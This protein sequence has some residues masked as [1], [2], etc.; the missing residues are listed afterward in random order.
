MWVVVQAL[1]KP[2]LL[3]CCDKNTDPCLHRPLF[4]K[5]FDLHS[6]AVTCNYLTHSCNTRV[7]QRAVYDTFPLCLVMCPVHMMEM[8]CVHIEL[9][10][11]VTCCLDTATSSR[12]QSFES[13]KEERKKNETHALKKVHHSTQ[14]LTQRAFLL[15]VCLSVKRQRGTRW[16]CAHPEEFSGW[17]TKQKTATPMRT[18][19][20]ARKEKNMEK[21]LSIPNTEVSTNSV[22]GKRKSLVF[23][24]FSLLLSLFV[25]ISG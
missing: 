4:H 8:C 13:V 25:F 6:A 18:H 7:Q 17:T 9:N 1:V 23:F 21:L 2:V 11:P 12:H 22:G 24:R 19:T 15:F 3:C 20:R 16:S 5:V 10:L 14:W